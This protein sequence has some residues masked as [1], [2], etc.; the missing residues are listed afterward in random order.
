M[1]DA[2]A[3]H[4][5]RVPLVTERVECVVFRIHRSQ[6]VAGPE[7]GNR[8]RSDLYRRTSTDAQGRFTVTGLAPG[9]YTFY[10]WDDV[11]R[12]AWES[13][14]FMR[15]FAGRGRFVRLREGNNDPLEL[16][17]VAGR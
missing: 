14:E 3:E 8:R 10:A 12:G 7:A 6:L 9:D 16:S 17:V 11:E 4:A 15:A 13:P 5:L 1:L 2:A